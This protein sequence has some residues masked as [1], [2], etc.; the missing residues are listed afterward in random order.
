[1]LHRSMRCKPGATT[2]PYKF[3]LSPVLHLGPVS[4]RDVARGEIGGEG[5]GGG[6]ARRVARRGAEVAGRV[7]QAGLLLAHWHCHLVNYV[8]N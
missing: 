7:D 4:S 8:I 1:M 5:G 6:S 2:G 3:Q